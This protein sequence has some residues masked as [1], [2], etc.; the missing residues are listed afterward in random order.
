MLRKCHNH[1][2]TL[3]EQVQI[4]YFGLTPPYR[5]NVDSSSNGSLLNRS[6]RAAYDLLEVMSEQSAMWPDR[7]VQRG[8]GGAR[9]SE[10]YNLMLSKIDSLTRKIEGLSTSPSTSG[11]RSAHMVQ[12]SPACEMCGANHASSSY[13]LLASS[14]GSTE[15]LAYAQNFQRPGY[16]PYAQTYNPGWRNHPNF[17]YGNNQNVLNPKP[18]EKKEGVGRGH[19]QIGKSAIAVS[20]TQ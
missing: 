1:G 17:S 19:C 8:V 4:F 9:D 16:N 2:I 3:G 10:A 18:Q 11:S 12:S 13:P 5:S 14:S 6:M 15:Q 7:G 20:G